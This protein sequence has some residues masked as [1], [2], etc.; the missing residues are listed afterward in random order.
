[1]EIMMMKDVLY[2]VIL[3]LSG[4]AI[5][6]CLWNE[7]TASVRIETVPKTTGK[8]SAIY[9]FGQKELHKPLFYGVEL[10]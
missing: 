5:I 8:F 2:E 1:M 9:T 10:P 7:R 3:Y 6:K 4:L